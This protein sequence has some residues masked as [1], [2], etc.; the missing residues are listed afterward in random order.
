LPTG[1]MGFG[2]YLPK[3]RIKREEYQKAWG[4][5][6][7]R[8]IEEKCVTDF[9]EDSI[10]MAVEAATSAFNNVQLDPSAAD[11][12]Y[13]A[14][15]T[16]PYAEKQNASTIATALGCKINTTTLDVTSSTKAGAAAL[17]S[18]LDFVGC[19]RGEIG[20]IVAADCPSGNPV[21]PLEHQFGAG[22]AALVVGNE[23]VCAVADGSFSVVNE[24]LSERFRRNGRNS[25]ST[26]DLGRYN[27]MVSETVVRSCAEGLMKKLG[28]SATDYEW[29]VLQ[30]LDDA[31]I[32]DL[33]KKLGFEDKKTNA[34]MISAKVGDTGTAASLLALCRV[35]EL[36]SPKQRVLLCSY[37]PGAGADAASFLIENK[38][39]AA[40][41]RAY[42]ELLSRKEYVDYTTYLKL[43]RNLWT[44]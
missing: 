33:G 35:F 27:E 7:P 16:P 13:F 44:D 15:T 6:S 40:A 12:V 30:G 39:T 5:F 3:L 32:L 29:L 21:E 9:D 38:M 23:G 26:V 22:A 43:R 41:G 18:C 8:G 2:L 24:S 25:V 11:A 14:S 42:D 28:R 10:T 17:L 19:G 4:Y 34:S 20:L 31:R 1:I 37:G 36:A